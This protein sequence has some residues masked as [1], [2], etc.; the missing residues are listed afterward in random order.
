MLTRLP[1]TSGSRRNHDGRDEKNDAEE[2]RTR[3]LR[4]AFRRAV[5]KDKILVV[6]KYIL[7]SHSIGTIASSM[8]RING[9]LYDSKKKKM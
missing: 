4:Y 9:C 8:I 2:T 6:T 7:Y 3:H 5:H 1:L